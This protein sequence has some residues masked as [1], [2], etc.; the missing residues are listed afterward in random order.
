MTDTAWE[1]SHS[2]ETD[3][4][5]KFAWDFMSNVSNWNDPPAEFHLDGTFRTGAQGSTQMP[6]QPAQPWQLV[7]VKPPESYT[8]EF[9][10]D[11]ATL[12]FEWRFASFLG[13]T[14]L[15]Q[16][17]RLSGENAAEYLSLVEQAL[18][19]NLAPGMER[20]AAAIDRAYS[21]GK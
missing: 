18:G 15:T 4:S 17:V 11:G 8:I 14:R 19:S 16:Q 9:A 13:G 21:T 2:V 6:G 12:T 1:L 7:D 20:I 3:A 10:L 5:Q